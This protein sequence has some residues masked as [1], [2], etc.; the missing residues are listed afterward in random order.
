MNDKQHA[1]LNMFRR[2]NNVLIDNKEKYA[3]IPAFKSLAEQLENNIAAI[4]EVSSERSGINVKVVS[5][6]KYDIEGQMIDEV[7]FAARVL[8][9]Y[10]QD[11]GN[12]PLQMTTNIT[13]SMLYKVHDNEELDHARKITAKAREHVEALENYGI[14]AERID[15]LEQLVDD[16]EQHMPKPRQVI[17]ERKGKT[18]SLKALF[19]ETKSLLI[20]KLDK[21]MGLFKTTD[22]EFYFTYFEARNVIN[23]SYRSKKE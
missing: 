13:K 22:P 16:F 12:Q 23:T 3:A 11:S 15:R 4:I 10:A 9:V 14:N 21:L 2:V 1:N 7:V 20:D 18:L 8:N 6:E 5:S 19:A 17:S